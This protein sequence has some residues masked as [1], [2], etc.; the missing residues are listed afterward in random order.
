VQGDPH[1]GND[2][3]CERRP[4]AEQPHGRART[5]PARGPTRDNHRRAKEIA[6]VDANVDADAAPLFWRASQNLATTAMLVR[7]CPEPA[8][9]EE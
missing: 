6:N 9:T 1:D 3:H 8:T 5:P 4:A 2:N 7:G